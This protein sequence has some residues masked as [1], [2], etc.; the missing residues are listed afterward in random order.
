ML[1]KL[2]TILR[3]ESPD[4]TTPDL[5]QNYDFHFTIYRQSKSS[6]LLPLIESLWLQYGAY[7]NLIIHHEEAAKIDEHKF[8][9]RLAEALQRADRKAAHEALS[10][11]IERSFRV[12]AQDETGA[13][14]Q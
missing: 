9:K 11:D 12:I 2:D 13:V 14:H 8:H 5:Q 7:L 6:V 10:Q 1:D 3:S 4:R